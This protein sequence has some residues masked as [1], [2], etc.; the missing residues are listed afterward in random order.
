MFLVKPSGT[1]LNNYGSVKQKASGQVQALLN[2][3][4][5]SSSLVSLHMG[6]EK[7]FDR[8]LVQKARRNVR[9]LF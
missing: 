4:S 5:Q 8:N 3:A 6:Q 7:F 2:A 1:Y 9:D